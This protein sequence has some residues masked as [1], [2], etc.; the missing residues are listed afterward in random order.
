M[1]N[2]QITVISAGAGSG[3]T[4]T[5]TGRM[6][7]MLSKGVRP[8]AIIATTFTKKAAAELQE[9]V[10]ARLLEEGNSEAANELGSALIG[11]VHSI[12]VKLLQRFAF[13]AGVSPL[14]EIIADGD[15]QR[16]FNESLSQILTNERT[17]LMNQLAERLGLSKKAYSTVPYDWRDPIRKITDVARANN[18]SKEVLE[19]SKQKSWE[20]FAAFLPP[21]AN[22]STTTLYNRLIS[23]LEQTVAALQANELDSTKVTK[24][25]IITFQQMETELKWRGELNWHEWVKLGKTNVGAKSRDL[26]ENLQTTVALHLESPDFQNDIKN[27]IA[28]VFDIATDALSEYEQYK[29]KRG[30]IDYTDMETYI[31]KLLRVESVRDTLRN[32]LDLLLVD[33]FQDTSPI[34][35]DIFLQLSQIAKHSIWVGDPKQ[36]I[37]GFRGAEPALM[38]AIIDATGGVKSENI[39]KKS[40]RSRPDIVAAVNAIF[41]KA[42]DHTPMEQVVLE[43]AFSESDDSKFWEQ[44]DPS[45]LNQ[46]SALIHWHFISQID[47]KKVPKMPWIEQCIAHQIKVLLERKILVFDKSRKKARPVEPGDIAVLCR[48]NAGCKH[49]AEALHNAGLKA[50]I[51]RTGLLETP[52]IKL[53]LAWLKR[54]VNPNDRLSAAEI[55][56]IGGTTTLE[57][58]LL[59]L[60]EAAPELKWAALDIPPPGADLH[61]RSAAEALDLLISETNLRRTAASLGNAIQRLDNIEVLR[62]Y[63]T[64]YESACNRLHTASTIGGFLLWLNQLSEAQKD[65]QGS[66]ESADTVNVL[67]YHRSKGLEYPICICHNLD[68]NLKENVWGINLVSEAAPNLD[69]ILA[70][71]WL[72]FWVNPYADQKTNTF[73]EEQV[74]QSEAFGIAT[75]QALD[76]EARLLYVG[77]TRARDYLIFPTSKKGTPWLNRVF[78]HGNEAA[79]TLQDDNEET[80]FFTSNG[81]VLYTHLE[82]IYQPIDIGTSFVQEPLFPFHAPHK[83]KQYQETYRINAHTEAIPNGANW[84]LGQSIT[85]APRLETALAVDS[86]IIALCNAIQPADP[87]LAKH[88]VNIRQ[89]E[90]NPLLLT[91]QVQSFHTWLQQQFAPATIQKSVPL[92]WTFQGRLLELNIDFLLKIDDNQW[93]IVQ[94]FPINNVKFNIKNAGQSMFT[95]LG[96]VRAALLDLY[97]SVQISFWGVSVIEGEA[98]PFLV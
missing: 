45:V 22:I 24:D 93:A 18:F 65:Y 96:W 58:L 13:E 29:Q 75:R 61:T 63:A 91:A 35:L 40:W 97:P 38:Q 39:L 82:Q 56:L 47:E 17:D 83:G 28:L 19:K 92:Q 52:E 79:T 11:T 73:L 15:E 16:L 37:Y 55:K 94:H 81:R 76:E 64:E 30:L 9:R 7:E 71:R 42:F 84:Q 4:Y 85:F 72:R 51:S 68:Q 33:E 86:T 77:L 25:A 54:L 67:T 74:K 3:K 50:G 32:E 44:H 70:G 23:A 66:G 90:I 95:T 78:S 49:V 87:T 53:I 69:N 31:S 21:V 36:S 1:S 14:V 62:R 60:S 57:T 12:G 2:L 34:Q 80:P 89:L 43:P 20:T 98:V 26:L 27:F 6:L 48:N 10:R 5:L 46:H 88:Q 8:S 41:V 59:Q